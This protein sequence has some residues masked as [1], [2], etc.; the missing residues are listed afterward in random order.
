MSYSWSQSVR[1]ESEDILHRRIA[2]TSCSR[3]R[4]L[5]TQ[6]G[7]RLAW[8]SRRSMFDMTGKCGSRQEPSARPK[9]C[10]SFRGD[11]LL[12]LDPCADLRFQHR[13]GNRSAIDDGVVEAAQVE[14]VSKR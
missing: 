13:Q 5:S 4:A 2:V 12:G 1:G 8:E 3:E 10:A 11:S 9:G 7:I 6:S 14:P